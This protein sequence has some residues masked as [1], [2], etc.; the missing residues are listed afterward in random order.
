MGDIHD[1]VSQTGNISGIKEAQAAFISEDITNRGSRHQ[2]EALLNKVE[3]FN[4]EILAQLG[5]MDTQQLEDFL[6]ESAFNVHGRATDLGSGVGLVGVG[7]ST[8]TPF[9]TPGEVRDTQIR[10]WLDQTMAQA[11]NFEHLIPMAHNPPLDTLTDR[12]RSGQPVGSRAVRQFIAKHEPQ[13]GITGHIHE[14]RAVDWLG[15]TRLIN[16]GFFG[17]GAQ[18][19]G[20]PC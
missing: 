14:S 9:G 8:P 17:T 11:R 16:P 1:D 4:A 2:A 6:D 18:V 15:K 12:V 20:R 13:V 10:V 19:L 5:K 3:H 7:Y